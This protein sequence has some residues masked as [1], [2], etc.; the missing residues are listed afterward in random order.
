[1]KRFLIWLTGATLAPLALGQSPVENYFQEGS[2]LP[3][4]GIVPS[5]ALA[6]AEAKIARLEKEIA[7]LR[8][9]GKAAPNG[10]KDRTVA[11]I[12][13][14]Q[15]EL[16][17]TRK[18]FARKLEQQRNDF[19]NREKGMVT[20]INKMEKERAELTNRFQKEMAMAQTDFGR[21]QGNLEKM[22]AAAETKQAAAA[23]K[24][25]ESEMTR[26][27]DNAAWEKSN[28]EW[29]K[30]VKLAVRTMQVQDAQDA[31]ANTARL[32]ETWQTERA[33]LEKQVNEL[34]KDLA[35]LEGAMGVKSFQN[36]QTEMLRQ[37]LQKKSKALQT[38]GDQAAQLA[39]AW[40]VEREESA[41]ELNAMKAQFEQAT[42]EVK[43][44]DKKVAVLEKT[45]AERNATLKLLTTE[46]EKLSESWKDQRGGLQKQIATLEGKL[47]ACQKKLEVALASEKAAV[48]KGKQ[49]T[50]QKQGL[51][52]DTR[53]L[54]KEEDKVSHQLAE[55]V[56]IASD[57]Q[58]KLFLAKKREGKLKA[59]L[60][61][62]T[63]QQ[64]SLSDEVA[65][66]QAE[67][68]KDQKIIAELRDELKKSREQYAAAE[69]DLA[70]S[71]A[72]LKSVRATVVTLREKGQAMTGELEKARAELAKAKTESKNEAGLKK[73]VEEKE[74]RVQQLES[75]LSRLMTAQ[76]ELEGTMVGTLR[77]YEKLQKDYV[78]LES[79]TAN[80]GA[81]AEKA[82]ASQQAAEAELA[83][84][85][86]QLAQKE[87]QLQDARKRIKK[88][89]DAQ[90]AE[91][92]KAQ[93]EARAGKAA[94]G[95]REA[96]LQAARAEL[97]RLQLGQQVLAQEAEQL[98][99]EVLAIAPVRYKLA[100]SDIAIQ[101]Q[102]VLAEAREVL[103][104]YP[105]SQF[106][107][108]GHTC[109]LGSKEGN[110]KLSQERAEGL[111]D[112]LIANGISESNFAET[113]G[114]AD[115]QPEATND[116]DEGRQKNR[117]VEIEVL[118]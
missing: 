29:H 87:K 68:K 81:S 3:P 88:A 108:T 20:R 6:E 89:E 94:L 61:T 52:S 77:D 5:G 31:V 74:S 18:N 109:N 17:T 55:K 47:K 46:A 115:E 112:F 66:Y 30:K 53:D 19:A 9:K 58:S 105:Q 32:A 71:E 110:L 97:G 64:S 14:L 50:E 37:G 26:I 41:R 15:K 59:D 72:K 8:A 67:K 75:Q 86:K 25:E 100:S 111:R 102:R 65:R 82:L 27:K 103:A 48:K 92:E 42:T 90:K 23:R 54:A 69:R 62:I 118:K 79:K 16:N 1:M 101:Q 24:L 91:K 99:S 80:G 44:H 107:I 73:V 7:A 45:L 43:A 60:A 13:A 12:A 39:K 22:V 57:L 10:Q 95:K 104:V 76:R 83:Q 51:L 56:A 40:R 63:K 49:L 70:Q 36:N 35:K 78:L 113:R 21:R 4:I 38:L 2:Q 96:E 106:Q 98:R 114:L 33:Q 11:T 28:R 93:K 117:R 34:T 84:I 85:R 116:S